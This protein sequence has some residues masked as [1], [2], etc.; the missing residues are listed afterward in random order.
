MVPSKKSGI[1]VS[2]MLKCRTFE[3]HVLLETYTMLAYTLRRIFSSPHGM[4]ACHSITVV[5]SYCILPD[6]R[7]KV[8]ELPLHMIASSTTLHRMDWSS[9]GA[10]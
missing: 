8:P 1:L 6:T 7:H 10:S 3:N 4:S 2:D 5:S 9:P